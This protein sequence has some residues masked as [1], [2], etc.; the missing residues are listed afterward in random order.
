MLRRKMSLGVVLS[1]AG[2][3]A[4]LVRARGRRAPKLLATAQSETAIA[5]FSPLDDSGVRQVFAELVK[6]LPNLV[7]RADLPL[8]VSLPDPLV[9]EDI[10][11]FKD[12]P[13]NTTEAHDLIRL[14]LLREGPSGMQDPVC[15]FEVVGERDGSIVTRVRSMERALRD[16]IE[17]AVR[18][19]GLHV[20]K[21]EG[22]TCF[23]STGLA[24]VT[25]DGAF[26]WSDGTSWSL[27]CWSDAAPEGFFESGW[28]GSDPNVFLQRVGRLMHSFSLAHELGPLKLITSLPDEIAPVLPPD[29][30]A[31]TQPSD[32]V[33]FPSGSPA[34]QVATWG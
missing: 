6:A 28:V 23:C 22:W 13:Q 27:T 19:S 4:A 8:H 15:S 17:D 9:D 14:R 33:L 11:L 30:A 3:E 7:R 1:M 10:L 25:G 34:L 24:K 5:G 20:A 18:A 2:G 12:F 21:L 31:S 29:V 26:L 16:G 32:S